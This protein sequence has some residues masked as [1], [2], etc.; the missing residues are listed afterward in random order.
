MDYS[1]YDYVIVGCGITGSVIAERLAV[2]NKKVLIVDRRNHIAGNIYDYIDENGILVQKYGPHIFHT[3]SETVM[4]YLSKFTKFIDYKLQCKVS[5]LGKITPS[6]FNFQ[7]IDDYYDLKKAKK[8][9]QELKKEYPNTERVSIIELLKSDNETIKEYANFL[10]DNDY[11]LYTAKQWGVSPSE[12]DVNVL[13]RVPILLNYD[14]D[15]FGDKYQCMPE[16]GFTK[17]IQNMLNSRNIDIKLGYD[18][19][20]DL[21]LDENMVILNN[22]EYKGKIIYTGPIDELFQ[23]QNGELDYRSLYFEIKR[24]DEDEYQDG[25]VVAY[26]A[27]KG[28]T[29]ITEYKKLPY[30]DIDGKT[31]IAIEYPLKYM[32]NSKSEPY[33]PISN[34]TNNKKYLEYQNNLCKFPNLIVCGRLG[35]YKYYNM[36]QAVQNALEVSKKNNIEF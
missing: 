7:T 31:T 34:P 30:Q 8:L 1:M 27:A 17:M 21:K 23:Y 29:R 18:I 12:I 26:P 33:Y 6:P 5:M 13:K 32:I 4:E 22:N 2:N 14:C 36:D 11:S 25:A 3:N 35:N 15:Y 20:N 10:F 16:L 9:K 24:L 19:L 28:F